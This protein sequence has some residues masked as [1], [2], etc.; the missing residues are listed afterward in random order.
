MGGAAG[1]KMASVFQCPRKRFG[2]TEIS[3]PI[4]TC[5]GMRLQQSWNRQGAPSVLSIDQV[6]D[7]C[8][9]NLIA[10]IRKCLAHGVT[11]FETAQGYG[12]SEVQFGAALRH[13]IETGELLR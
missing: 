10:I 3:M 9:D 13:L 7:E 8:Q 2:R 1:T 11:H 12:S 6:S 5:G 4:I